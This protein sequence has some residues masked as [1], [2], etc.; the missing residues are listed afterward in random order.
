[1][2]GLVQLGGLDQLGCTHCEGDLFDLLV[3]MLLLLLL[4]PAAC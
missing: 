3:L 2:A 4:L 1:V